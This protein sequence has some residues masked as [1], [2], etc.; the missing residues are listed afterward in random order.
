MAQSLLP[1]NSTQIEYDV[2]QVIARLSDI[3]VVIGDLWNPDTCPAAALPWLAWALSVDEWDAGWTEAQRRAAIRASYFI[4][5]HKGTRAAV[6]AALAAVDRPVKLIEWWQ[7]APP[8]PPYTFRAEVE[9][10]DRGIDQ[11]VFDQVERLV[12]S[13]KNIRSE[14]V[15][16]RGVGVVRGDRHSALAMLSG[17]VVTVFPYA[18]GVVEAAASSRSALAPVLLDRVTVYPL[19]EA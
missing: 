17:D 6:E 11:A 16:L 12:H 10:G 13:A 9:V 8:G 1:P 2:E 15:G 5:K 18:G 7:D 19:L 4:H 3:P 14:M